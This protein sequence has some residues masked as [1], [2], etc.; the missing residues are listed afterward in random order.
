[1]FSCCYI[2]LFL[3]CFTLHIRTSFGIKICVCLNFIDV[4]EFLKIK[5]CNGSMFWH[6]HV[7]MIVCMQWNDMTYNYIYYS[8]SEV[9]EMKKAM[10]EELRKNQEE[11]ENM[12]KTWQERLSEQE[13]ANKVPVHNPIFLYKFCTSW[14]F[15]SS[16]RS[17]FLMNNE[18]FA[19]LQS[20]VD[21][22]RKKQEEKKVIPHFW[23]LHE[24]PA[25]TAMI[26][27]FAR[28]GVFCCDGKLKRKHILL[29]MGIAQSN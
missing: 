6:V 3:K 15:I 23:N 25:L 5:N 11:I 19:W 1:M 18:T 8:K 21:A 4:F 17:Y 29:K 10:E 14:R 28:E 27:H 9:E 22:E 13:T 16:F 24:D 26:V 2:T 12:K 20:N 7:Y